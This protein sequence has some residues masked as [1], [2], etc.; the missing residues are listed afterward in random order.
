[1]RPADAFLP[2]ALLVAAFSRRGVPAV[3]LFGCL[4]GARLLAL[5][6]AGS[7]RA[8]F[9]LQPSMRDVQGSVKCA[10]LAQPLGAALL[11]AALSLFSPEWLQPT[12]LA[13][14]GGGLLLN[15][16]HVF[17][18][19]LYS[20]GD[21]G[22]ALLS[23]LITAALA[24]A[25]LYLSETMP[26]ALPVS[27]G[28]AMLAACAVSLSVGGALKGRLNAQPLRSA[29]PFMLQD[30][31]YP[32]AFSGMM[33]ALSKRLPEY[34][35]SPDG[36]ALFPWDAA[37]FA[38]L[39]LYNLCRTSFRRSPAESRALNLMLFIVSVAAVLI[40]GA[41]L[42][43][44]HTTLALPDTV[45]GIVKIIPVFSAAVLSAALCGFALFGNIKREA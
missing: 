15:L 2:A 11:T 22:S 23:R 38:G 29:P 24:F 32:A 4:L 44:P 41:A 37:F 45:S 12:G 35:P 31:A 33:L 18:E 8:A 3:Y 39:A 20:A 10:L 42:G 13:F 34:F 9:S 5:S 17:Y 25:G 30:L 16:E 19:Y 28:A 7:L 36:N 6:T 21:G 14:I 27:A 1:M 40:G 26:A 43:I